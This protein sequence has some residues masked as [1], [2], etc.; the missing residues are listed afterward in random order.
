MK[1]IDMKTKNRIS[2]VLLIASI[3]LIILTWIKH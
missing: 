1:K 2:D 3:I